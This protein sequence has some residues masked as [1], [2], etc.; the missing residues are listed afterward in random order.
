MALYNN[1]AG[2]INTGILQPVILPYQPKSSGYSGGSSSSKG[3]SGEGTK[4]DEE[5]GKVT[6]LR[7]VKDFLSNQF[8]QLDMMGRQLKEETQ[9]VL[10]SSSASETEIAE[11]LN[12]Y[13]SGMAAIEREKYNYIMYSDEYKRDTEQF[14]KDVDYAAKDAGS[15]ALSVDYGNIVAGLHSDDT[16]AGALFSNASMGI[17]MTDSRGNV[18]SKNEYLDLANRN[19]G[20]NPA[21]GMN[22][23]KLIRSSTDAEYKTNLLKAINEAGTIT[24]DTIKDLY[25]PGKNG[26]QIVNPDLLAGKGYVS[27]KSS[28][29]A[30]N[31]MLIIDNIFDKISAEDK[32]KAAENLIASGNGAQ[33]RIDG[34]EEIVSFKD[35]S[36]MIAE[37]QQ[38][39]SSAKATKEEK[40]AATKK[41]VEY[42]K[43]F[44]NGVKVQAIEDARTQAI[45]TGDMSSAF[46]FTRPSS[47]WEET[48]R[49][50]RMHAVLNPPYMQTLTRVG[51]EVLNLEDKNG[52]IRS[53][54]GGGL[55]LMDNNQPAY[56]Y[57]KNNGIDLTDTEKVYTLGDLTSAF[58]VEGRPV[59]FMADPGNE[60]AALSKGRLVDFSRVVMVAPPIRQGEF[61]NEEGN[62]SYISA[63]IEIPSKDAKRIKI[64]ETK[65]D[66]DGNYR[67]S[68]GPDAQTVSLKRWSRSGRSNATTLNRHGRMIELDQNL[69]QQSSVIVHVMIPVTNTGLMNSS[70]TGSIYTG[71]IAEQQIINDLRYREANDIHNNDAYNVK[72]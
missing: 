58:V 54:P 2:Y 71:Q 57:A 4:W 25:V 14:T 61:N 65:V 20:I 3:S 41:G 66:K 5:L 27:T 32:N 12:K 62:V 72:E 7:G 21:Y 63:Y 37:Q 18:V 19:V 45:G 47:N 44:N 23:K 28:G 24:Q 68:G 43:M 56:D 49:L 34:K 50:N 64:Q 48:T 22:Y 35:L 33:V 11:S 16:R 55:Y 59:D 15:A 17:V 70:A 39:A 42:A 29:D 51:D 13:R 31:R 52:L 40:A 9:N 26:Q 1:T 10:N 60:F 30:A 8:M 36:I 6:A 53:Y 69:A 67:L 46:N 38:I